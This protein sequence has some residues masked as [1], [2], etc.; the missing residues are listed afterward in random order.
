MH[1]ENAIKRGFKTVIKQEL[2]TEQNKSKQSHHGAVTRAAY[3]RTAQEKILLN[4]R[5][6]LIIVRIVTQIRWSAMAMKRKFL[7][8]H[9]WGTLRRPKKPLNDCVL[10][11]NACGCD[12]KVQFESCSMISFDL[13]EKYLVLRT[14][15]KVSEK[16]K[17]SPMAV[18]AQFENS[19]EV[20]VFA[21]LT[22]AYCLVG[23]GAAQN[24]YRWAPS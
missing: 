14:V 9:I 6:L 22:N 19:N 4:R 20:G 21:V 10:L 24:F 15:F 5:D 12:L 2:I 1:V 13:W 17:F 7:T 23:I 16:L 8:L 18:R 11:C 3:K